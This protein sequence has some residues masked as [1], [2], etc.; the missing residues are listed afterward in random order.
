MD[1]F[2]N[3][4]NP[5]TRASAAADLIRQKEEILRKAET[6]ISEARRIFAQVKVETGNEARRSGLGRKRTKSAPAPQSMQGPTPSA[7]LRIDI[8][9]HADELLDQVIAAVGEAVAVF[10]LADRSRFTSALV[11]LVAARKSIREA[12][13][14]RMVRSLIENGLAG[15]PTGISELDALCSQIRE[16]SPF[17]TSALSEAQTTLGVLPLGMLLELSEQKA[18]ELRDD[19]LAKHA[20]ELSS[21]VEGEWRKEDFSAIPPSGPTFT[22]AN[23]ARETRRVVDLAIRFHGALD[24]VREKLER[25]DNLDESDEQTLRISQRAPSDPATSYV[26][27]I[28]KSLGAAGQIP[29]LCDLVVAHV[30][31]PEHSRR[32]LKAVDEV[33]RHLESVHH[34]DPETIIRRVLICFGYPERKAHSLFE[35]IDKAEKRKATRAG[36]APDSDT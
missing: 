20:R 7:L 11:L 10:E 36:R 9:Q 16:Y 21:F 18:H 26:I 8:G 5:A 33:R 3:G 23:W 1:D 22:R 17:D 13:M 14:A 32:F 2:D 31:A 4:F 35:S 30:D 27:G 19:P 15:K 28:L 25:G 34:A 24:L 12:G 29:E 6:L